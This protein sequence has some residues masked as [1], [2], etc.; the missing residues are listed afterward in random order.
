[1]S[2]EGE[3]IAPS[4]CGGTPP[5]AVT[6]LDG[7]SEIGPRLWDRGLDERG[8]L[9]FASAVDVLIQHVEIAVVDLPGDFLFAHNVGVSGLG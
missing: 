4:D 2:K 7:W 1:M 9:L 5:E 6:P 8:R 3:L